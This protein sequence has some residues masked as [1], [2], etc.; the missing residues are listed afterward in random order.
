M[1]ETFGPKAPSSKYRPFGDAVVDGFDF[2]LES[3][4]PR[5]DTFARHLRKLM[6]QASG[7]SKTKSRK[8]FYLTAAPQCPF[9]DQ[10]VG[11]ILNN[12]SL[13]AVFVQF[14]NNPQCGLNAFSN[15]QAQGF[16]FKKWDQWARTTSKNKKVKVLVGA[17]ASQ[18]AAGSGYVD[19]DKLRAIVKYSQK[20][21]SLGGVMIWDSSHLAGNQGLLGSLSQIIKGLLPPQQA[22]ED[23]TLF[24]TITTTYCPESSSLYNTFHS[25]TTQVRQSTP[26]S[27]ASQNSD[28]S[29]LLQSSDNG[30]SLFLSPSPHSTRSSTAKKES[31]SSEA[32]K[33]LQ[34]TAAT[35]T[36]T[37]ETGKPQRTVYLTTWVRP[38]GV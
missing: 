33:L 2:D 26:V 35:T 23:V 10:N 8:K 22:S 12:V 17:P 9:P 18:D 37:L 28:F 14:Y 29:I 1:W 7:S 34:T 3:P 38:T 27:H 20:F 19:G 32:T 11:T 30:S 21:K 31:S 5:M 15:G 25:Q 13:D 4:V 16:N 36:T 24:T 6:N